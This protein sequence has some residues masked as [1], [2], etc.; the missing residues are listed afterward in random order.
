[1]NDTSNKIA[2]ANGGMKALLLTRRSDN[3]P[4]KPS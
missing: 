4:Q 3:L 2:G 1:M